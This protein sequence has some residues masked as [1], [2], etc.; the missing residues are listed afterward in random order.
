MVKNYQREKFMKNTDKET[1]GA[2]LRRIR[3]NKG[4]GI[5]KLSSQL[6]ITHSYISK[7]ENNKSLPSEEFIGKISEIFEYDKEELMI[8]AGRVPEDILN[9][10]REN[11]KEA[12]QYLRNRFIK[13]G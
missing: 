13:D 8:R 7:I 2:I 5:K 3:K 1:F 4:I 11:P 9:I 6:N 12:A 10:L